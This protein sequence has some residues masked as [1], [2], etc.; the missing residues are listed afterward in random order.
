M[1]L[2]RSPTW[3]RPVQIGLGIIVVILSI[4]ALAYP[5]A[6]FVAIVFILGIILFIVGIEK[7]IAGIFLPIRVKASYIGLGIIVLIFAG[8]VIAFPEFATWIITIFLGIALLFGG[9]ASIAQAFSGK[10]SGWRKGFLLGVGALLVILG[11]IVLVS[12]VFG[13]QFAGFI[14]AIGLLIAGIQMIVAGATGRKLHLGTE[15]LQK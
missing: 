14:V 3:V 13:A 9:A 2:E 4:Y 8:I 15:R 7:I 12:P 5:G 10:E 6:A 11:I 1:S